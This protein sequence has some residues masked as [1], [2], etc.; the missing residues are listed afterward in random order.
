MSQTHTLGYFP[1]QKAAIYLEVVD[2]NNHRTDPITIPTVDKILFPDITW[3]A[4]YPQTMSR[5][6][7]GLY[8]Y[9]FT[10]PTGAAAIGNYLV[11][12]SYVNPSDGYIN[13][14]TYHITVSA[15]YGNFGISPS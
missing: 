7:V 13:Y 8:F 6:D 12:A 3:V 9:E 15:P 4:G 10:L 14:S 1:G 2:F 5:L 11:D